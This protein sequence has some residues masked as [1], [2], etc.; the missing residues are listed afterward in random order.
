MVLGAPECQSY[1]F[2]ADGKVT[3]FTGEAQQ[4]GRV[5]SNKLFELLN[6]ICAGRAH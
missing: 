4:I 3:S 5:G 6:L 1:T 2:D